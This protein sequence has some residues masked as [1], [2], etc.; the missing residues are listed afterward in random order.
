M[1]KTQSPFLSKV[2]IYGFCA[3]PSRSNYLLKE[4]SK[5]TQID[6]LVKNGS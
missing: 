2:W 3:P 5:L 4:D 1:E 6:P